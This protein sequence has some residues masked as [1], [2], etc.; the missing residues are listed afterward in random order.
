MRT[1]TVSLSPRDRAKRS[2][3][4]GRPGT[5]HV[6]EEVRA[7]LQRLGVRPSKRM[8]Q[9]FLCDPFVADAEAALAAPVSG[10]EMVEV[11]GGLGTLT[12]ALL[13]RGS[14]P[15]LVIEKDPR[16]VRFLRSRFANR[17]RVVEADAMSFDVSPTSALVGNLPFSSAVPL[18]LRWWEKSV[19][20]FVVLVQREVA[21]RLAAGPG[22]KTYG[23]RSIL[24]RAYGSVELSQVVPRA[25]FEPIPEVEG[26]L[27]RFER[28]PDP[29]PSET[30]AELRIVL[31]VL[32]S[33]RRK[34]LGNLLPRV[35]G[36]GKSADQ[37]A[38]DAEWPRDWRTRR[39]EQLPPEAFFRLT[40]TIAG[41]S[42]PTA[43]AVPSRRR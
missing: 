19:P 13:R 33:S 25:A 11:G 4:E 39:P 40:D 14:H 32:F 41:Q 30:I 1:S 43:P 26:Q 23:R 29:L 3:P 20:R 10:E 42:K 27:L 21:E 16:L 37:A 7:T 15:L 18:I 36:G 24:A 35:T 6:R 9:S 34:Q 31:R 5:P 22:S 12:E 17:I 28:R 38:V 8:G 2:G